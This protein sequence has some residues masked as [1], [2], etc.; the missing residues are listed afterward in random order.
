MNNNTNVLIIGSKENNILNKVYN[1]YLVAKDIEIEL[2]RYLGGTKT[3]QYNNAHNALE[4]WLLSSCSDNKMFNYNNTINC[5]FICE[6]TAIKIRNPE[7][8]LDNI[9]N[10]INSHI[11]IIYTLNINVKKFSDFVEIR[12][13][14]FKYCL[15]VDRYNVLI[16]KGSIEQITASLMRYMSLLPNGQ[17]WAIPISTYT[18]YTAAAVH[19]EGYKKVIEGFA[20]PFNSQILMI[21]QPNT[22]FCSLFRD[23]DY[24]FGSLGSFFDIDDEFSDSYVIV[25]PPFI[26]S[27]LLLAAIKCISSM[28]RYL[29]KFVFYGP[30]WTDAGFYKTLSETKYLVSRETLLRRTYHYEDLMNNKL[31]KANFDSVIFVMESKI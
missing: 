19:I 12:C 8:L 7:L 10:L 15:S 23:L 14:I 29:C 16:N 25:N 1:D 5:K 9:I 18:I 3:K 13:D 22:Y 28:D 21:D 31:I 27:I 26:E 11:P 24:P 4:R 2:V 20:S 17:Q 6:L 30:N